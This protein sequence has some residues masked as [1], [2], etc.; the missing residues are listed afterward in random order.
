[1][2]KDCPCAERKKDRADKGNKARAETLKECN[3]KVGRRRHL[4]DFD[5]FY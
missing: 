2:L 5:L 3:D 1:M 4:N